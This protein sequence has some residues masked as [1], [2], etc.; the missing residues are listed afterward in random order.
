MA[1]AKNY[2]SKI[3]I[4]DQRVQ[5]QLIHR[6]GCVCSGLELSEFSHLHAQKLKLPSRDIEKGYFYLSQGFCNFV[7]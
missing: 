4:C 1:K 5:P 7:P 6:K 3:V 2:C